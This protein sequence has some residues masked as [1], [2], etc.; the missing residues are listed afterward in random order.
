MAANQ[1]RRAGPYAIH[2]RA[3]PCGGYEGR[4]IGQPKIVVAAEGETGLALNV[5]MGALWAVEHAAPADEPRRIQLFEPGFDIQH[6][7]T[8]C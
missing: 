4:V 7:R 1:V 6:V 5:D 2:G 3:T 8:S